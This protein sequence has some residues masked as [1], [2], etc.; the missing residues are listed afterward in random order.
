MAVAQRDSRSPSSSRPKCKY[1]TSSG[2][3]SF[4]FLIQL[5]THVTQTPRDMTSIVGPTRESSIFI[6]F[7]TV[8]WGLAYFYLYSFPPPLQ[9][10]PVT[11]PFPRPE[12]PLCA[13]LPRQCWDCKILGKNEKG[14]YTNLDASGL[15]SFH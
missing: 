3:Q 7:G 2:P 8:F 4:C 9:R 5:G 1:P 11:S 13:K 15:C 10:F 12:S 14:T 6:H